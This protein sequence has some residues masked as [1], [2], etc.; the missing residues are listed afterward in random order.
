MRDPGNEVT[1]LCV[2]MLLSAAILNYVVL[3]NYYGI[4]R[5]QART[6]L[7]PEYPIKLLETIEFKMNVVSPKKSIIRPF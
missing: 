6:N 3:K 7:P 1:T 4:L 5:G 2:P